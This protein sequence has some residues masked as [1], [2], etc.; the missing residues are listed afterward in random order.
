VVTVS[1]TRSGGT[2]VGAVVGDVVAGGCVGARVAAVVGAIVGVAVG[3]AVGVA[4]AVTGGAVVGAT[5]E[6]VV[7]T[8]DWGAEGVDA[9]SGKAPASGAVAEGF[10]DGVA[11][12]HDATIVQATA[13][14]M[15]ARAG[16]SRASHDCLVTSTPPSHK[17]G[18]T[19]LNR[20]RVCR[21][22]AWARGV[23]E[24]LVICAEISRLQRDAAQTS[25]LG[26]LPRAGR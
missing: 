11:G 2:T 22:I 21:P 9:R 26:H 20:L 5:V 6:A 24:A 12:E 18:T 25:A 15:T 13:N 1:V 19:V 3:A 8:D 16:P 10:A 23:I 7:A 17:E 14:P 4:D